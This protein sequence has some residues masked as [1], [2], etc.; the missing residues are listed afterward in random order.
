MYLVFNFRLQ[1]F[2]IVI[3][4]YFNIINC[5][6]ADVSDTILTGDICTSWT[7]EIFPIKYIS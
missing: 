1:S 2:N 6:R 7:M 4:I 5:I 3:L